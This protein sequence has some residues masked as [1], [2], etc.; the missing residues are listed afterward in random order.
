MSHSCKHVGTAAPAV[1]ASASRQVRVRRQKPDEVRL[2]AADANLARCARLHSRGGC[3]YVFAGVTHG[4][5]ET[6]DRIGAG[7]ALQ[8]IGG[9]RSRAGGAAERRAV[10]D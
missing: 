8:E 3:A 7:Y 2:L 1:Q 9:R 4:G 5:S 10:L 6:D